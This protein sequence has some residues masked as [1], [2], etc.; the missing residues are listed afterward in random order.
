MIML[1]VDEVLA[2]WT[3]AALRVNGALGMLPEIPR[4]TWNL[5]DYTGIPHDEFWEP[6]RDPSFWDDLKPFPR[7][8][9]FVQEVRKRY[10]HVE[11]HTHMANPGPGCEEAKIR[12]IE[13]NIGVPRGWV[14][15]Y[16]DRTDPPEDAPPRGWTVVWGGA[17]RKLGPGPQVLV[18]DNPALRE[19]ARRMG[20]NLITVQR[21]WN[22]NDPSVEYDRV[23]YGAVLRDLCARR[24]I[25]DIHCGHGGCRHHE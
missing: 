12:W 25:N 24:Q 6:M 1:D 2:N 9:E 8:A 15:V 3:E 16:R 18:D 13:E 20:A 11:I 10:G 23:D 14:T 21:P 19:A 22:C 7:A 17:H 5:I 4:N